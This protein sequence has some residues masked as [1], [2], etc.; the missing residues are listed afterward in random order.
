M[1]SSS[2][3]SSCGG[4]A[5]EKLRR[6]PSLSRKSTYWPA[7]NCSRSLAGSFTLTIA[8][9][10]AGL[11]MDSI[12]Q[13]SRLIGMSPARRTSRT[14]IAMSLRGFAQQKSA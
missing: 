7:R 12:R 13:G 10:A 3:A 4:F 11:S 2:S 9:S 6:L 5:I 1:C 14:S 8:T